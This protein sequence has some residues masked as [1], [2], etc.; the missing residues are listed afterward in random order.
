M[1]ICEHLKTRT[2]VDANKSKTEIKGFS[3]CDVEGSPY[4]QMEMLDNGGTPPCLG[5]PTSDSCP[6]KKNNP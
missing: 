3:F 1:E 2:S 6:Y 5:D 4:G